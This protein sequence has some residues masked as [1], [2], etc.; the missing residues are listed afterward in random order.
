M[1][2]LLSSALAMLALAACAPPDAGSIGEPAV[3]TV[4]GSVARAN[5]GAPDPALEPLFARYELEFSEA[6]SFTRR[7]LASLEQVEISVRYPEGGETQVF[8]GPRMRDV[9]TAAGAEGDTVVIL[10]FDGYRREIPLA[11]FYDHG[12]VLALERNGE[13]LGIGGFG[14]AML[15]WPRDSDA[16]L[17]GQNDDDWVWG[18]FAVE[19]R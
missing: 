15:A 5:R 17:A 10:A 3:L 1:I 16:A 11:R 18:V 4:H 6:R 19:V 8:S 14:P 12:V 7:D 9:L 2:R 13:P